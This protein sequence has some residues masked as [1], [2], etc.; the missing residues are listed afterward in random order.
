ML[1]PVSALVPALG[2]VAGC[3][4]HTVLPRRR[5]LDREPVAHVD[6]DVTLHP[7]RLA[8][9]NAGEVCADLF[10]DRDHRV[11]ADVRHV[12]RLVARASVDFGSVATPA[13]EQSLDQAD[14]VEA[15]GVS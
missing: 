14:A 10:A 2:A 15:E 3:D 1:R 9:L 7:H 4:L 13:P 12:I 11:G 6:A 8:D 5:A